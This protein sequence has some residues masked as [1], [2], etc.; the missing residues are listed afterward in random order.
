MANK[1]DEICATKRIEVA[2][3]KA[4]YSFG[5]L[6]QLAGT[7]T[8][9]RG[10]RSALDAK[11][12]TG[13][14]LIAEIKKASPSKGLIRADFRPADHA[15]A[16]LNRAALI[17][18]LDQNGN[19]SPSGKIVFLA[20]HVVGL[21]AATFALAGIHGMPLRRFL[22]WDGLAAMIS[23]P[24]MVALGY[25]G[26]LHVDLVRADIATDEHYIVLVVLVG[27]LLA[28]GLFKLRRR[29]VAHG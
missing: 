8:A 4:S 18:L 20:R 12:L 17:R 9:P 16:G 13:F 19:P 14:G 25:F 22:F 1:L 29:H 28:Y 2:E 3:R 27:G 11:A 26:A 15:A 24:I 10:F 6:E 21:R 23:V 5:E 7:Q